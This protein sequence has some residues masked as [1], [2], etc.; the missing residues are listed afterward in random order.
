MDIYE[1]KTFFTAAKN[2]PPSFCSSSGISP[3]S[4][5]FRRSYMK[6]SASCSARVKSVHHVEGEVTITD[7]A[8]STRGHC[9]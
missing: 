8:G 4:K 1:P 9:Y 3:D 6:A 2:P 5:R 7:R